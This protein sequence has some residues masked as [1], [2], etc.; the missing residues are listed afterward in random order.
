M[1][2]IQKGFLH[3]LKIEEEMTIKNNEQFKLYM[4]RLLTEAGRFLILELDQVSYLNSSALGIIADTAMKARK[5][6]QELVIAGVKPPIDEIFK[7]V[8]FETFM[9]LFSNIEEAENYFSKIE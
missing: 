3:I 4:T 5:S 1:L 9:R 7:I 6:E 8:K 2:I